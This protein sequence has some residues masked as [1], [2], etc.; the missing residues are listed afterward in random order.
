MAK[1]THAHYRTLINLDCH[2]RFITLP[3]FLPECILSG[4]CSAPDS[5]INCYAKKRCFKWE[6]RLATFQ[7][8][9]FLAHLPGDASCQMIS[10]P[11]P[12]HSPRLFHL[13]GSLDGFGMTPGSKTPN[14]MAHSCWAHRFGKANPDHQSPNNLPHQLMMNLIIQNTEYL[15]R[16]HQVESFRPYIS[17]HHFH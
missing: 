8:S 9:L 7:T 6:F 12:Q 15:Y 4:F 13:N 3:H 2:I 14:S 10:W 1:N 16:L 17:L 5:A 11:L